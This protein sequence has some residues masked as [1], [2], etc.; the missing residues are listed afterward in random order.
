[1]NGL[2]VELINVFKK[3]VH[4]LFNLNTFSNFVQ[5]SISKTDHTYTEVNV[6]LNHKCAQ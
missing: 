2:R 4:S 1:M 5:Q 3:I 6:V